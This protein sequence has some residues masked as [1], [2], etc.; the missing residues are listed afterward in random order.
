MKKREDRDSFAI[1]S[2]FAWF[3]RSLGNDDGISNGVSWDDRGS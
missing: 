1:L 3:W 2:F